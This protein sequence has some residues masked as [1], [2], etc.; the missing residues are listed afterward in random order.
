MAGQAGAPSVG[1]ALASELNVRWLYLGLSAEW[2]PFGGQ[3]SQVA[4]VTDVH[5]ISGF[6]RLGWNAPCG[7]DFDC[8][9]GFG[10]GFQQLQF[11]PQ[12]S[13]GYVS[14]NAHHESL[15]IA[16]ESQLLWHWSSRWGVFGLLRVGGLAHAPVLVDS[17]SG[18]L[19]RPF[20]SLALGVSFRVE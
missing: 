17:D 6:A 19:G 10:V 9:F 4:G 11:R 2:A 1:F 13:E 3:V 20:G 18:A 12:A 5:V 15:A 8:K 7:A 16:G 14:M